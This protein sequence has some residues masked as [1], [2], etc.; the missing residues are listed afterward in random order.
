MSYAPLMPTT[1]PQGVYP[2]A[3]AAAAVL[4]L[5]APASANAGAALG[6]AALGHLLIGC[7]IL[8]VIEGL[9]ISR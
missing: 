8:G 3:L 6:L 5:T 9:L 7:A 4:T 1:R 2:F